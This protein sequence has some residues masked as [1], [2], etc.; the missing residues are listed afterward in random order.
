MSAPLARSHRQRRRHPAGGRAAQCA[1]SPSKPPAARVRRAG[2]PSRW[3][4]VVFGPQVDRLRRRRPGGRRPPGPRAG[5]ARTRR[6]RPG[7][8]RDQQQPRPVAGRGRT[9]RPASS[10]P[11]LRS[12]RVVHRVGGAAI[13]ARPRR[14]RHPDRS[15]PRSSGRRREPRSCRRRPVDGEPG[16][17]RVV[18]GR[19]PRPAPRASAA[20]RRP[21]ARSS[22][23]DWLKW[24]RRRP[25]GPRNQ[26]WIGVSGAG[27]ADRRP[28]GR[29]RPPR[30]RP[31]AAS[32]AM[33]WCRNRSR[34]VS[35]R[36]AGGPG[37]R[38]G[39]SGWSRRRAR[40][41]CRRRRPV[42]TRSTS[43]Q[44]PASTALGSVRG[45]T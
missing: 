10:G 23:S 6:R 43:A 27:P 31:P 17:Q 7:G 19:P 44:M 21:A 24:L 34:E 11:A 26:R 13:A 20:G 18:V 15:Q 28:L 9:A 32:A 5:S 37:R 8:G 41:S 45:A 35:R 3:N 38:P 14:S 42:G 33:V 39:C 1:S 36:P 2:A 22:S 4:E 30:C 25:C 12:S 16:P 29:G 40:R